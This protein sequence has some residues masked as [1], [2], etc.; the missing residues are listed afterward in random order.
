M[1]IQKDKFET[2]LSAI[3]AVMHPAI[4]N[5]LVNLGIVQDIELYT[6]EVVIMTFVFPF[7]NIPIADKLIA[8]L[9]NEVKKHGMQ[10]QYIVRLMKPEEKKRFLEL[11]KAGWKG[12]KSQCGT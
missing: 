5:S 3:S 12:G 8:S 7:P 1:K 9:E 10:M 4:D 6:D 11:E 2:I